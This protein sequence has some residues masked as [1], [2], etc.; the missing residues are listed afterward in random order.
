MQTFPQRR[1]MW[2]GS[3]AK[4]VWA[5]AA[6]PL[7]F[8]N[9]R[10]TTAP[11][12]IRPLSFS[13]AE[14]PCNRAHYAI[15]A[16]ARSIP[17]SLPPIV[18]HVPYF[19]FLPSFPSHTPRRRVVLPL[20]PRVSVARRRGC[21]GGPARFCA[22]Y[23]NIID[24]VIVVLSV[25]YRTPVHRHVRNAI[26]TD[27]RRHHHHHHHYYHYHRHLHQYVK[28]KSSYLTYHQSP[29]SRP[30]RAIQSCTSPT[31][32]GAAATAS[33]PLISVFSSHPITVVS[34]QWYTRICRLRW[35]GGVS[36]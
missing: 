35:V 20:R 6:V 14:Y 26:N 5:A 19:R 25:R 27:G 4:C 13:S 36:T 21:D 2:R 16:R 34:I 17:S 9:T 7:S 29:L 12:I 31:N 33:P 15:Y 8:P 11:V 22:C 10:P 18:P 24:V 23:I 32:I 30:S 3:L 28:T 1:R